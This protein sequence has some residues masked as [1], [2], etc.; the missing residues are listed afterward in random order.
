[1]KILFGL[2]LIFSSYT[3]SCDCKSI[4]NPLS[5][6]V[7]DQGSHEFFL[8][9][10]KSVVKKKEGKISYMEYEITVDKK[11]TLKDAVP[12]VTIRTR[13]N[14]CMAEF[15]V[16]AKYLLSTTRDNEKVRWT[17][18]CHFKRTFKSAKRYMDFLDERYLN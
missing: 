12:S 7:L 13:T 14:K 18:Q 16:G 6:K 9:T 17:D 11:Y 1:M 15:V 8:G 3:Y 5:E 10:I 4:P 2:F